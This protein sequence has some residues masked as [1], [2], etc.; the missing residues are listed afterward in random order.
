MNEANDKL[1]LNTKGGDL[2]VLFSKLLVCENETTYQEA[3]IYL[4]QEKVR[5]QGHQQSS[6]ID[7]WGGGRTIV[8]EKRISHAESFKLQKIAFKYV[9]QYPDAPTTGVFYPK[10]WIVHDTLK[11]YLTEESRI[12]WIFLFDFFEVDPFLILFKLPVY[13]VTEKLVL[14]YNFSNIKIFKNCLKLFPGHSCYFFSHFI[15]LQFAVLLSANYKKT[16][17]FTSRK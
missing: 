6:E 13:H 3:V 14:N 8:L 5:Y 9:E 15:N 1:N 12:Y 16:V 4:K 11:N 10:T 17:W 2:L 7:K